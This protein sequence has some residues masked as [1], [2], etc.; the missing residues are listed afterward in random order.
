MPR[1]FDG[2]GVRSGLQACGGE[3]LTELVIPNGDS[4]V[5]L[6]A[7][8]E[9]AGF[10]GS[11]MPRSLALLSGFAAIP[12]FSGLSCCFLSRG[13]GQAALRKGLL[14]TGGLESADGRFGRCAWC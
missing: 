2:S 12:L 14:Q 10:T 9:Q 13:G 5:D 4:R 1:E 6:I 7:E 11:L 8:S 3:C